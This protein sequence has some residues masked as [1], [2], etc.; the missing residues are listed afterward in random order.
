MRA[1]RGNLTC[2]LSDHG[3]RLRWAKEG[4]DD[5]DK[6]ASLVVGEAPRRSTSSLDETLAMAQMSA[7]TTTTIGRCVAILALTLWFCFCGLYV[8]MDSSRPHKIDVS[9]GRI[10]TINNHGSIAYL[11]REEHAFLYSFEYVAIGLF[12]VAAFFQYRMRSA[13]AAVPVSRGK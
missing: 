4:V 12:I 7:K 5:G 1:S 13:N 6:S 10:Y 8:Y 2:G 3:A 11:T 9:A